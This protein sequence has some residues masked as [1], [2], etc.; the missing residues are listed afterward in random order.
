MHDHHVKAV[1]R[2]VAQRGIWQMQEKENAKMQ[3]NDD[4]S[5]HAPL[6]PIKI[7]TA[8]VKCDKPA[9]T[10]TRRFWNRTARDATTSFAAVLGG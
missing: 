4:F 10:E 7:I 5:W 2:D 1:T 9:E 8:R 6:R 3:R